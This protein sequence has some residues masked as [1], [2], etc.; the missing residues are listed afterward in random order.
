MIWG[1]DGKEDDVD[2]VDDGDDDNHHVT[3]VIFIMSIIMACS[4]DDWFWLDDDDRMLKGWKGWVWVHFFFFHF[5]FTWL[6]TCNCNTNT[7]CWRQVPDGKL[8]GHTW[9]EGHAW[10]MEHKKNNTQRGNSKF[11][12]RYHEL[13]REKKTFDP[14]FRKKK[15]YFNG[16]LLLISNFVQKVTCLFPFYRNTCRRMNDNG[17]MKNWPSDYHKMS[18][19]NL[20]LGFPIAKDGL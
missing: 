8:A 16:I 17:N 10:E 6:I 2:D 3:T 9:E 19:V 5:T 4:H 15:I 11:S 1:N 14:L 12:N 20:F 7:A 18:G 13:G